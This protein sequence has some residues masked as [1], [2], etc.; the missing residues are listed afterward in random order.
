MHLSNDWR[1]MG[2]C[3][4]DCLS[5]PDAAP[6]RLLRERYDLQGKGHMTDQDNY[7]LVPLLV[8]LLVQYDGN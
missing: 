6:R 1:I 5:V 8:C 7:F 4:S 2:V 3:M